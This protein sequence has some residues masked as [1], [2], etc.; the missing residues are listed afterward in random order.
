MSEILL[1]KLI[2]VLYTHMDLEVDQRWRD[3]REKITD[4][5]PN[6]RIL[7][8]PDEVTL[9]SSLT[10]SHAKKTQS[11]R[12]CFLIGLAVGIALVAIVAGV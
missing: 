7:P 10:T 2:L 12:F 6:E 3:A 1:Q 8:I 5:H 9:R 11:S 4:S